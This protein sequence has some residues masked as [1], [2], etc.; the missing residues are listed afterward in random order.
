MQHVRRVS[1]YAMAAVAERQVKCT[2]MCINMY[3]NMC[4]DLFTHMCTD[5]QASQRVLRWA[6]VPLIE[7]VEIELHCCNNC[8]AAEREGA[9]H[10]RDWLVIVLVVVC[11]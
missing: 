7:L 1:V 6:A 8:T 9:W 10:I 3:T 11:F 2:G 5:M 4:V